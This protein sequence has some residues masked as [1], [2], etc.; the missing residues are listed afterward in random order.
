MSRRHNQGVLNA[1]DVAAAIADRLPEEWRRA[2]HVEGLQD[3]IVEVLRDPR[4][5]DLDQQI[6][7]LA[8][9]LRQGAALSDQ[10]WVTWATYAF[11]RK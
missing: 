3:R 7:T 10:E 4:N 11:G 9:L 8:S 6:T 2:A 5:G 1:Q